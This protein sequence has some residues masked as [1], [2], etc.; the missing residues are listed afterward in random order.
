MSFGV[1]VSAFEA[2]AR[3]AVAVQLGCEPPPMWQLE[4]HAIRIHPDDPQW[5]Y[6][7]VRVPLSLGLV[8]E[9]IE[10]QGQGVS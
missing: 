10:A 6:V 7:V 3:D 5:A 8:V 1:P 2:A 9:T 4:D